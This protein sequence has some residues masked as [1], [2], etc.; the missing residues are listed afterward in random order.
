MVLAQ[1]APGAR[2]ATPPELLELAQ[3]FRA[4]RRADRGEVDYAAR[5]AEARR[6]YAEAGYSTERPLEVELRYNSGEVHNRLAVAIA[7]MRVS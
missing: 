6:L 7:A 1:E 4:W 5:V 2:A 3:E